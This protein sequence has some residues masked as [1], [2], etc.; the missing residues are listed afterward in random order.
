MGNRCHA[1]RERYSHGCGACASWV[2]SMDSSTMPAILQYPP[3]G[4]HPMPHSVASGYFAPVIVRQF[5]Q[6]DGL[7]H[8]VALRIGHDVAIG[9]HLRSFVGWHVG[10]EEA[11]LPLAVDLLGSHEGY[12]WG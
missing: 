3:S 11:H 7:I 5:V 6:R 8:R 2:V 9:I 12:F 10:G 1:G 4:T